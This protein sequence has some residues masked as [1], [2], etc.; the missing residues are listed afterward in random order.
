MRLKEAG[1]RV[2]TQK[3][4]EHQTL[5]VVLLDQSLDSRTPSGPDAGTLES[6]LRKGPEGAFSQGYL[7]GEVGPV[8]C[9]AQP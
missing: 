3:V 6:P 7:G 8:P 5:T 9:K 4:G 2:N 1:T